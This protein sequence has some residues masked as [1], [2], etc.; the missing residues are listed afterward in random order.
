M[1]PTLTASENALLTA[2]TNKVRAA[3]DAALASGKMCIQ[4]RSGQDAE[5]AACGLTTTQMKTART[6]GVTANVSVY[7][8]PFGRGWQLE[9]TL[10]RGGVTWEKVIHHGPET[11]REQPWRVAPEMP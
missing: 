2:V 6:A 9:L 10:V 1:P 4:A 7:D 11:W 3:Q 8:G 5:F